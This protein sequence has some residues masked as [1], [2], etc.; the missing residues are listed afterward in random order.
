MV[1]IVEY[2]LSVERKG[3]SPNQKGKSGEVII[4]SFQRGSQ[5]TLEER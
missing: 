3:L 1:A 5:R 4:A 2:M